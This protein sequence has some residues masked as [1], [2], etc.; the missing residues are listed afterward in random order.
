VERARIE[1]LAGKKRKIFIDTSAAEEV[2]KARSFAGKSL[3]ECV[4][5]GRNA[6][7]MADQVSDVDYTSFGTLKVAQPVAVPDVVDVLICGGGPAGT[8]AA[9]R[10]REIGLSQLVIDYDDLMK[11]IRDYPKGKPILPSYGGGDKVP[12][13]PGGPLLTSLQFDPID[14]DEMV[15]QWKQRYRE[16]NITAKIGAEFTGLAQLDGG[17]W[18]V[19][20]WSHRAA[21]EVKYTARNVILAIG[22]GV[23]RR[24][25]IPGN[26]DGLAFRLDDP[27]KYVG[28]PMLVIGGG[29]SAAEA[30]I[31][32]SNAKVAAKD[33]SPLYWSYRADKLPKVSKALNEVFFDA[34]IGNGNIRYL[35]FSEPVAVVV[36]PD[37]NEYLSVQIDRKVIEGRPPET[38]HL[39]FPKSRVVACIGEDLPFKFLQNMGVKIP[40]VN[41][42]A[43]MLVNKE[44]E[45]SLPGIFLAGDAR[46]PKFLQ[47][48]DFNNSSTYETVSQKRNIKAA[49][50]DAVQAVEV[51]G[52]RMG[53]SGAEMAVAVA[54]KPQE[55]SPAPSPVRP[56]TP[57]E[58]ADAQRPTSEAQLLTLHPDGTQEETFPVTKDSMTIGRKGTDVTADDVY[59]A[60]HHASI[61]KRGDK[62]FLEDTGAGSG[63]WIRAQGVNGRTLAENDVA[64]IGSQILMASKADGRWALAHYNADGAFQASYPIGDKGTF[65]GRGSEV[66]LD[67]SDM[68][69]SRRHAQFRSSAG[70]LQVFDLGSTNG[71]YVK[72]TA[73][74]ALSN[75]D[76][77]RI[78][79]KR[80]RFETFAPVAKLAATD[81]V[82]EARLEPTPVAA[83]EP[84][85]APA[86]AAAAAPAAA[87]AAA[88]PAAAVA[89]GL[90]PCTIDHAQFPVSF[91]VPPGKDVLHGYF[92]FLK[93]RFPGLKLSSK[94]EPQEHMDEPLGW[95]CK[96]GLCGLCAIEITEGAD[97]FAAV[98][99]GSPE[100]NTVTNK[101]FLDNDPKKFRLACM[102]KIKGPVK[103]AMPS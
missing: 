93:T 23:P 4:S 49:M 15:V 63:V 41:G 69:L 9:M 35:A 7:E 97:N 38:V 66:T 78:A 62:Y 74:L 21:K 58:P 13:P 47:C 99:P 60:D 31:A 17:M 29:T 30:V 72:I 65:V 70:G 53:K 57:S 80:F 71:T 45:L 33:P 102:A 10:A 103:L 46:G 75:G 36:G 32:I 96:V 22:A 52:K 92:D 61:V 64:W 37:K 77:F 1:A 2:R 90:F 86:A 50:W 87:P 100:M 91:G 3:G 5:W 11:R 54:P 19:K 27:A 68:S 43:L 34:Y 48:T 25:D 16:H 42:R 101:A 85:P 39:E 24:F 14:K 55:R 44:G 88:A 6:F 79:S 26:T 12:F 89:E 76:E 20:C 18:E 28:A 95:E 8:A 59:M 94:G 51:I 82:V 83:P 81:V 56:P 40:Q 98:D 67:K 73:P 84:G